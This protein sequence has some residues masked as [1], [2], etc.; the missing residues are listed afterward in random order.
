MI[1]KSIVIPHAIAQASARW[2]A[3]S[4]FARKTAETVADFASIVHNLVMDVRDSYRPELHYMRGPGPKWRAKYQPWLRFDSEAVLPAGQH[5]LSPVN[6]RRPNA[7][8]PT[9]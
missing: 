3:K 2:S 7:A 8:N 9:G 6:I 4:G 1:W 5:R